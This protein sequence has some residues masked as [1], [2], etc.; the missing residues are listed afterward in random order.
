[1]SGIARLLALLRQVERRHWYAAGVSL[2]LHLAVLLGLRPL[3]PE[4]PQ[5]ITFEIALQPPESTP[6]KLPKA[7][8]SQR[9]DAAQPK[10]RAL[11][12]KKPR[13]V[14]HPPLQ[15]MTAAFVPEKRPP[16]QVPRVHLP[17]LDENEPVPSVV[18]RA[19]PPAKPPYEL[20]EAASLLSSTAPTADAALP[21]VPPGVAANV[22][23]QAGRAAPGAETG[24][25]L[26]A[27]AYPAATPGGGAS[28]R[29]AAQRSDNGA[30]TQGA[31]SGSGQANFSASSGSGHGL[32]IAQGRGASLNHAAASVVRG[33]G[34]PQGERLSVS[35]VASPQA[36]AWPQGPGGLAAGQDAR[37]S[38]L[39]SA[40]QAQ[41]TGQRFSTSALAGGQFPSREPGAPAGVGQGGAGESHRQTGVAGRSG[42]SGSGL[43][44]DVAASGSASGPARLTGTPARAS[45]L[46]GGTRTPAGSTV[47]SASASGAAAGHSGTGHSGTGYSGSE[48]GVG[49][50]WG[51]AAPSREITGRHPGGRDGAGL[52]TAGRAVGHAGRVDAAAAGD[53]RPG[54][55]LSGVARFAQVES[56]ASGVAH[57]VRASG[58]RGAQS[59]QAGRVRAGAGGGDA[60]VGNATAMSRIQPEHKEIM[61]A[62]SRVDPLDVI[63]PS[64]FCPLPGHA[65]P[66]VRPASAAA[67]VPEQTDVPGYAG[68]NPNLAYP[69]L[70][71]VQGVEGRL[72]LR[73]QVQADGTPGEILFKKKS[74][75][76]MLD[77]DARQQIA[78][79][80]FT[81]ARK[82][83]QPV[84][85][86]VDVPVN[87]RLPEGR[88]R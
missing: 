37:Q 39:V 84:T 82:F 14:Q 72:I 52:S 26:S 61:R 83:G 32:N 4:P 71:N 55:S 49:A 12:R 16:R 22:E 48:A 38:S 46:D 73:V 51:Q 57:A 27:S 2:L 63:A 42:A 40:S 6:P 85:A 11:R 76:A 65:Q 20:A 60:P 56:G 67:S 9:H 69:V 58:N 78:R 54:G 86:W 23:A 30:A 1:M 21:A 87:Y 45:A 68:H 75:N 7:R 88:T 29:G 33:G 50:A 31:N 81:P 10:A 25:A 47:A 3:P 13:R 19:H 18:Q 53:A 70:A 35:G 43:A 77:E 62:D 80:R 59:I 15:D 74:G 24:M 28:T 17:R 34:E 79:W 66:G 41:G 64:S 8:L 5:E 44:G 36:A